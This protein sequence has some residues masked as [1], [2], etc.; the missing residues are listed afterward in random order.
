MS[1]T[2]AMR[3]R[4][5]ITISLGQMVQCLHALGPII[6]SN[7]LLWNFASPQTIVRLD[8]LIIG[9]T[10]GKADYRAR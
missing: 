6:P 8:L 10:A 3:V 4:F 5:I 2:S 1:D 7:L 9:F